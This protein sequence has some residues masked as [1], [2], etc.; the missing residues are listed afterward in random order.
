[1]AVALAL[2]GCVAKD[3]GESARSMEQI[4]AQEGVPV[5]VRPVQPGPFATELLFNA[6]LRGAAETKVV[7]LVSDHVLGVGV[8]VGEKVEK[9]QVLVTFPSDSP[10]LGYEQARVAFETA[11]EAYQRLARLYEQNGVSKQDYDNARASYEVAKANWQSLQDRV[12]VRAPISGTV[13]RLSIRPTD[14]VDAGAELLTISNYGRLEARV[15]ATDTEIRQLRVGLPANA[16]WQEERIQGRVTQVDLAMDD[17]REAFMVVAQFDNPGRSFRS[18]L[19]AEVRIQTYA[20]L[21]AIVV[22]RRELISE[23]TGAAVYVAVGGKAVKRTVT[24]GREQGAQVE[25]TGGLS[26]GDQLIVES[27]NLLSDGA[28]VRVVGP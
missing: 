16:R 8:K 1:M 12:H 13:T 20:N 10:S 19:T 22:Q 6:V 17:D 3:N 11:E 5:R 21:K 23:D 27:L 25:V 4:Y 9:D 18:G 2:A 26:A 24:L 28:R 15:W 14:Y 7:A